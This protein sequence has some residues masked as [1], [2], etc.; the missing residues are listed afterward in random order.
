[1]APRNPESLQ[2]S[3]ATLLLV[4]L[5]RCEAHIFEQSNQRSLALVRLLVA[6]QEV[7]KR[8]RTWTGKT[9]PT[10]QFAPMFKLSFYVDDVLL[11]ARVNEPAITNNRELKSVSN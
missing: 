8:R 11:T 7:H 1:M 10:N 5:T 3:T 9:Q 4:H 2:S 6:T